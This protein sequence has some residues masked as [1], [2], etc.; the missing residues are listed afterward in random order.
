MET[1]V[2]KNKEYLASIRQKKIQSKQEELF[3]LIAKMD[4]E[5]LFTVT[6]ITDSCSCIFLYLSSI[7]SMTLNGAF[8]I[9]HLHPISAS[10]MDGLCIHRSINYDLM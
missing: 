6:E 4:R 3:Q 7:N 8:I 2:Q 10:Y 5:L 1:L 9:E